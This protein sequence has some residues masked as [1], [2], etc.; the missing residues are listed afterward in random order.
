MYMQSTLIVPYPCSFTLTILSAPPQRSPTNADQGL[1]KFFTPE[2][3]KSEGTSKQIEALP[4]SSSVQ[5]RR[6]LKG[7]SPL[8][9][10]RQNL[11]QKRSDSP[12][13]GDISLPY[14]TSTPPSYGHIQQQSLPPPRPAALVASQVEASSTAIAPVTAD[15]KL[16]STANNNLP[17]VLDSFARTQASTY[18]SGTHA[19]SASA[20]IASFYTPEV[21]ERGV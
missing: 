19:Q 1:G 16:F 17:P 8:K 21:R 3:E 2:E 11:E 6:V 7:V 9:R 14:R 18:T 4:N 10:V 12:T 15:S 20:K 5:F 13:S